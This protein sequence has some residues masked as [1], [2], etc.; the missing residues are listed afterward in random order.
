MTAAEEILVICLGRERVGRWI[1]H[2]RHVWIAYF[3]CTRIEQDLAGGQHRCVDD[4]DRRIGKALPLSGVVPTATVMVNLRA[5]I[6]RSALRQVESELLLNCRR[7]LDLLCGAHESCHA[8]H[9]VHLHMA[10][11][12]EV[13]A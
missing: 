11:D 7:D 3:R 4:E 12:E 6:V 1:E 9:H 8:L 13:A 2:A 10:V 5:L